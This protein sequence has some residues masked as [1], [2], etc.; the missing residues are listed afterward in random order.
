MERL[1]EGLERDSFSRLRWVVC[2][3]LGL[4][5]V[6]LR[7]MTMTRKRLIYCAANLVL[8]MGKKA[9]GEDREAMGNPKFDESMFREL[10]RMK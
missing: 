8:D 7:A 10:A 9:A 3:R 2:R 5:P 4:S 1:L 6:S